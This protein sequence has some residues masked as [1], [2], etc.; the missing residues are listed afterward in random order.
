MGH[1]SSDGFLVLSRSSSELHVRLELALRDLS[2]LMPIDADGDGTVTWGELKSQLSVLTFY[3]DS[4]LHLS[5][6]GQSLPVQWDSMM[7]SKHSDGAYVV[8]TG[9]AQV[10]G[11]EKI[12]VDYQLVFEAD[13]DHRGLVRLVNAV[14]GHEES[15][16]LSP[17]HPHLEWASLEEPSHLP[18]GRMV[19]EGIHHIWTGYDHLLFL[20]ALLLP[21][22]V[23]PTRD[24]R[25]IS[26]N[27]L[28]D[29]FLRVAKVVTAFTIAHS[30][31]LAM[32]VFGWVHLPSRGVE[33][34]IA[35]SVIAAAVNNLWPVF[36]G[37]VAGVAFLFGLIHGFGFASA[38]EELNL[39]AG[40]LLRGLFEFNL[41]VEVGQLAVVALFL[42]IAYGT[43][44]S[45]AYQR[46]GIVGGSVLI[47]LVAGGWLVERS[48]DLRFMPF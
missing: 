43:R 28:R 31:T 9:T 17:E 15:V 38:L 16:I 24:R 26:A 44:R 7:V 5:K 36:R 6:D 39:S 32:A 8:W 18:M 34:V 42:P 22:V 11:G 1:T 48:L 12:G 19:G 21:S 27:G 46:V 4:H 41:G 23:S 13:R 47:A 20:L 3:R 45:W 29:V 2:V 30:L 37:H 25:W 33:S 10:R 14:N 40:A 35:L